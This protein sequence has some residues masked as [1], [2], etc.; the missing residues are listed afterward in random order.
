MT[1]IV[2]PMHKGEPDSPARL[3]ADIT[4]EMSR[5]QA[6]EL[7]VLRVFVEARDKADDHAKAANAGLDEVAGDLDKVEPD[8]EPSAE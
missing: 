4:A 3:L 7:D 6:E 1:E 5:L 8:T 2:T